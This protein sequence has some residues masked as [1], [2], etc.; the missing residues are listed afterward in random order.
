MQYLFNQSHI[1][2]FSIEP[3]VPT[4]NYNQ[5]LKSISPGHYDVMNN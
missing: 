2:N 3:T 5:S 4:E 1:L